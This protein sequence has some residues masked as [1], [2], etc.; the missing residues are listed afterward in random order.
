M[1]MTFDGGV[2]AGRKAALI[3][4]T[5]ILNNSIKNVSQFKSVKEVADL[6]GCSERTVKRR[7]S[8]GTYIGY[9]TNGKGKWCVDVDSVYRAMDLMNGSVLSTQNRRALGVTA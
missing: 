1:E 9:K 2:S 8:D 3:Q 5:Q 7:I 4:H 6:I